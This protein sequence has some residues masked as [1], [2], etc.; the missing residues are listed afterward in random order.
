[1]TE[2]EVS[3]TFLEEVKEIIETGKRLELVEELKGWSDEQ[4]ISFC[5][6]AINSLKQ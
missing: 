6:C 3:I 5:D 2:K 1:M 4:I